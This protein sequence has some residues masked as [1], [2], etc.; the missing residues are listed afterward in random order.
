[1]IYFTSD[2]HFFHKNIAK[3]CPATRPYSSVVE[4]NEWLIKNHNSVMLDTD[5]LYILGDVSFG[6]SAQTLEVLK[7]M[8]GQKI[9]IRGN[10]DKWLDSTSYRSLAEVGVIQVHDLLE[11]KLE[12]QR[13][14]LCHYAMRTWNQQH[15]GSIHLFGHSHGSLPGFGKSMDVGWD[16]LG[17]YISLPEVLE[18]MEHTPIATEDRH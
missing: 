1:M 17:Q 7:R 4:M 6:N 12:R 9:V 8:N 14:I 18:L 3:H 10:H 5:T 15:R 2:L 16:A 11:V 13:F